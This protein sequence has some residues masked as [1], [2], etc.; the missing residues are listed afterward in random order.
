MEDPIAF[1]MDAW[2][3]FSR[4]LVNKIDQIPSYQR[5]FFKFVDYNSYLFVFKFIMCWEFTQFH[6][7]SS[8]SLY[9]KLLYILPLRTHSGFESL[10]EMLGYYVRSEVFFDMQLAI[11]LGSLKTKQYPCAWGSCQQ[12]QILLR[13]HLAQRRKQSL[14]APWVSQARCGACSGSSSFFWA[15]TMSSR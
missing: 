10:V 11:N 7:C 4:S 9:I 5:L 15:V 3:Q 2:T 14:W 13:F 8:L 12:L 1:K 6:S